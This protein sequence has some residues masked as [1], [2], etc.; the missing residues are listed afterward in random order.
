MNSVPQHLHSEDRQEYERIL[1]EAL[2]SAPHRPELAAVGQR[3]NPEQLRTMALNATALIT[4][5]AATEY[6]YYVKVR[7]EARR[8]AASVAP[9]TGAAGPGASSMGFA[10][11]EI[12]EAVPG[13]AMI[14]F[15]RVLLAVRGLGH[16]G[17]RRTYLTRQ[18]QRGLPFR[19]RLLAA[20]LGI[21]TR[22]DVPRL[23][24]ADAAGE[25]A[26]KLSR[27]LGTVLVLAGFLGALVALIC[28][29][30][31]YALKEFSAAASTAQHLVTIG[32]VFG[33]T[34]ASGILIAAVTA[35][36][37]AARNSTARAEANG[38]MSGNTTVDRARDAWRSAL[39]ERGILPFFREA[40]ADPGTAALHHTA[41]P[42]PTSR[43][44]NLGYGRPGF[45]ND[46]DPNMG[47]RPSFTSPDYTSPDFGGPEHRRE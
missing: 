10:T 42:A 33:A 5:A 26:A 31:G 23:T 14:G 25:L 2:R 28:L 32:S 21:R 22:P 17:G 18:Q 34:T 43:M 24:R 7:E 9:G 11:A 4:V 29:L 44:P 36:I 38:D 19:R 46:E 39:L 12:T 1:D 20:V 40:L 3:L 41:P 37:T 16:R 6:Q 30:A 47:P 45:S 13:P 27:S 8:P 15:S 35:L